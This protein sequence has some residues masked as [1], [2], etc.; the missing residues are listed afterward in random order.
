M[1]KFVCLRRS[2]KLSYTKNKPPKWTEFIP[3]YIIKKGLI[4][5]YYRQ[6]K[7]QKPYNDVMK[8]GETKP[9]SKGRWDNAPCHIE[10]DI[11]P[12]DPDGTCRSGWKLFING[13]EVFCKSFKIE[14]PE[15][16]PPIVYLASL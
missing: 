15:G 3:N 12:L 2:D 13:K 11:N 5:I 10:I 4:Y 7:T 16:R 1:Y 8:Y 9:A 6:L 14:L